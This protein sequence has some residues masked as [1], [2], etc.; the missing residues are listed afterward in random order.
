[1]TARL[2]SAKRPQGTEI[3]TLE[4][5]RNYV[6]SAAFSLGRKGP[7]PRGWGTGR[8]SF[9]TWRPCSGSVEPTRF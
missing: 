6:Y 1:M 7:R 9:G 2:I 4:G 8:F 5:Y 3:H